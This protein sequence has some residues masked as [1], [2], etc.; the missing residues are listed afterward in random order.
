[1]KYAADELI[2]WFESLTRDQMRNNP[3]IKAV[4]KAAGQAFSRLRA[5]N[6][7]GPGRPATVSCN[8]GPKRPAN[9]NS[10]SQSEKTAWTR[11]YGK[12]CRCAECRRANYPSYQHKKSPSKAPE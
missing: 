3:G 4:M 10:F 7:A 6:A 9:W 8:A 1:M 12:P 11:R 2:A 5:R